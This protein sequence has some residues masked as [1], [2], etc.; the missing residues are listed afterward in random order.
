[1]DNSKS[2]CKKPFL[3]LITFLAGLII[4]SLATW[5]YLSY[6]HGFEAANLERDLERQVR[7]Q[8]IWAKPLVTDE[9]PNLYKVS[10]ILYRG[11]QPEAEGFK[12]LKEMGIKTVINLRNFHSDR[13]EIGDLD[14]NYQ[15][16]Y[17]TAWHPEEKELVKFLR[18]VSDP[19]NQPVFVHCQHGAD[20]TGTMCALYRLAIDGWSKQQALEEMT[21]GGFGFHAIW[22]NLEKY[23]LQLDVD[24]VQQKA[25]L[26][27]Q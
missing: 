5:G 20:R 19:A 26:E 22:K 9:L 25:G 4:G 1:M 7:S 2:N 3:R 11:A 12:K 15:H 23:I 6:R 10:D 17:M 21:K 24:A 8:V 18:I 13:D 16:I 14:F 27:T